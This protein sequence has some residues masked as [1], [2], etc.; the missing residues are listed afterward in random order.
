MDTILVS[1]LGQVWFQAFLLLLQSPSTL[2]LT[3]LVYHLV[4]S[5]L[6]KFWDVWRCLENS[7]GSFQNITVFPR[8]SKL[9]SSAH[10]SRSLSSSVLHL[11]SGFLFSFFLLHHSILF[12]RLLPSS[13]P[14]LPL[15]S[16]S[17]LLFW[18]IFPPNSSPPFFTPIPASPVLQVS[19]VFHPLP[20][21]L[22][23]HSFYCCT[24]RFS[25]DGR[26]IPAPHSPPLAAAGVAPWAQFFTPVA[27]KRDPTRQRCANLLRWKLPP[28]KVSTAKFR[29]KTH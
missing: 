15:H 2:S 16:F 9:D 24:V 17:I 26:E 1:S 19:C 29:E 28:S 25:S 3:Y 6:T 27:R 21:V 11:Q 4:S 7:N 23:A 12:N 22:S 18:W 14:A 5:N 8:K 20:L 13:A 10:P